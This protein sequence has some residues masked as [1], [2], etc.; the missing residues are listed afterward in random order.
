M[1]YSKKPSNFIWFILLMGLSILLSA[2]AGRANQATSWP[3]MAI[4]QDIIFVASNEA[5]YAID[6]SN[7]NFRWKFVPEE[8]DRNTAFYAPPAPTGDGSVIVGDYNGAIYSLE[9]ETGVE[10]WPTPNTDSEGRIIGGATI[11]GDRAYVP[12][13]D[14]SLYAISLEDGRQIWKY[15][16]E[17]PLWSAPLIVGD[18]IYL[19]SMDHMIY[20][21]DDAGRNQW[22]SERMSGAIADTPALNSEL[23]L[24]GTFDKKLEAV[25]S[26]NGETAWPPYQAQNW[27]WGSP[28]IQS[29]IA[30]FGDLDGNVY[31]LSTKNGEGRIPNSLSG[32]IVPSPVIADNILFVV[33]ENGE[34]YAEDLEVG[35]RLW[36]TNLEAR[37]LTK[38]IITE[39][40][41]VVAQTDGD[42]LLTALDRN[43]G[44]IRWTFTPPEE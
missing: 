15:T 1:R 26:D 29:D 42:S 36:Q 11:A 34:V 6:S 32:R 25:R 40:F 22:T 2:C 18:T 31:E 23:L 39:D 5:V 13:S 38:P 44:N 10:Q 17:G 9:T 20:A 41:I 33:S 12:S 35:N 7:G 24:V 8:A 27:V 4:E 16:T 3:G 21:L 28:A 19:A 30:Y 37:L 43:N 14:H